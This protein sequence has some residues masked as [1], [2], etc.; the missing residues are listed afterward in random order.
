LGDLAVPLV[1]EFK[2]VGIWLTSTTPNIF[3]KHYKIKAAK[4]RKTSNA[5]FALKHRIGS[6]PIKEGIQLYTARVDCY[7][8]SGAEISLDID[9]GLINELVHAQELYLRRLLGLND[10]SM[11]AVLYTETGVEPIKTRRLSLALRRLRYMAGVD[12]DRVLYTA[13][14]DSLD[15]LSAGKPGWASDVAIML[16]NLPTPIRITPADFLNVPN[17][18]AMLKKVGEIGDADLQYDIDHLQKTHLLRNRLE[19]VDDSLTLVTRKLR[20]YLTMVAVPAHRKA[21]TRLLLGDHNLNVERLRYPVRYRLPIPREKRLCRFCRESIEDEVHTLL[22]CEGHAP[23]TDLREMFLSDILARDH[24]LRIAYPTISHYDFLRRLVVSRQSVK[25]F[26][27]Y[28]FD[29][30]DKFD[31]YVRFIPVGYHVPAS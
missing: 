2:Y 10:R 17:I 23:L 30:M 1:N 26:A 16:R 11:L 3:S 21:L 13:L 29:V 7:L 25:C 28:V 15:L 22:D 19:C 5:A 20:H 24:A 6:M 27:K 12:H 31:S 9:A 4:A 18:E 14:L 8:I